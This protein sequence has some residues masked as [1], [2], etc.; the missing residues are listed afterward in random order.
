[1]TMH[2]PL[3]RI[4]SVVITLGGLPTAPCATPGT[5]AVLAAR[6]QGPSAPLPAAAAEKLRQLGEKY[7]AGG[8]L[9][10]ST[11]ILSRPY[12]SDSAPPLN[13]R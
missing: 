6:L 2:L 11:L 8:E 10:L 7:R 12:P 5:E 4:I 3:G 1:M 13:S 9:W